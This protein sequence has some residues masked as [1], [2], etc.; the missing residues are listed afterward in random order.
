MQ[1]RASKRA[2]PERM[3]VCNAIAQDSNGVR[4]RAS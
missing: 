4:L 1:F 2:P 3:A